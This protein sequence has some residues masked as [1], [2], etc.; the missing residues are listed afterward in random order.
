MLFSPE[1][2]A[3]TADVCFRLSLSPC[4]LVSLSPC[5]PASP[6]GGRDPGKVPPRRGRAA[7]NGWPSTQFKRRPL[8]GQRRPVRLRHD[9]HRRHHPAHGRQH[10]PRGQVQGQHPPR[11]R[12]AAATGRSPTASS[13]SPTPPTRDSATS[14]A[15]ASASFSCRKCTAKRT[16]STGARKLEDVLT[17][18]SSSP[19]RSQ[20]SP[21]RLG[22]RLGRRGQRLRRGLGQ[23]HPGA[24]PA[25]GPQRRHRPCPR[26]PSTRSQEYL[27]KCTTP[28]G[29]LIYSLANGGGPERPTITCAAIASL[30]STGEYTSPAGQALD[31]SSC[32]RRSRSTASAP[33][34][35][36]TPSTRTTTTPR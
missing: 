35:S 34:S 16:T 18:R 15:T 27:R 7:W 33:T 14:T 36:A 17:G 24:G 26:R 28:N 11:R 12:L 31:R 23:R 29:G 19:A 8:G 10:H 4:L 9:R 22:L 21:R 3:R 6:R 20:T 2:D 5:L 32:S 25:G 30:F 1:R 13:A